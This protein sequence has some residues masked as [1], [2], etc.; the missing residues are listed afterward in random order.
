VADIRIVPLVLE[1]EN[2][3]QEHLGQKVTVYVD[4]KTGTVEGYLEALFPAGRAGLS[5]TL[6]IDG[7]AYTVTYG[8]VT[9]SEW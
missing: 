5:H 1:V 6:V 9:L 2:L 7:T 4:K 8:L 3:T